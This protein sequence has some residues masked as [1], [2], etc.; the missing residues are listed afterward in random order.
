MQ[1]NKQKNSSLGFAIFLL[2][3]MFFNVPF[4]ISLILLF[5]LVP[6]GLAAYILFKVAKQGQQQREDRAMDTTPQ[7]T[8]YHQSTPNY[9][10]QESYDK[11]E[12]YNSQNSVTATEEY[13]DINLDDEARRASELTVLLK[14]GIIDRDEYN[15]RQRAL[16]DR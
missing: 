7:P 9:G 15:E 10:T 3:L 1:Q 8:G 4:R 14:A 5:I 16:K 11:K 6:I 13:T 12:H 2:S